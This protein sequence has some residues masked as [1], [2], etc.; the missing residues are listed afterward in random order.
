MFTLTHTHTHDTLLLQAVGTRLRESVHLACAL[1]VKCPHGSG[2]QLGPA[3]FKASVDRS[4]NTQTWDY[5][6]GDKL[7]PFEGDRG[8]K[9]NHTEA[10]RTGDPLICLQGT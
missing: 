8:L 10:M 4:T 6:P 3:A 5:L 2:A 9:A 1:Y 7:V